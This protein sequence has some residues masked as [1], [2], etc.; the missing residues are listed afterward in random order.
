MFLILFGYMYLL[1]FFLL[2]RF[3]IVLVLII[4]GDDIVIVCIELC[5]IIFL[6]FLNM[7][8]VFLILFLLFCR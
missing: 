6:S 3:V 7:L 2:G 1:N 5:L 4:C 8:I